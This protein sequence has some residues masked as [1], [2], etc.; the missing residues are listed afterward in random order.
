MPG[1]VRGHRPRLRRAGLLHH[2]GRHRGGPGPPARGHPHVP[3]GARPRRP[4]PHSRAARPSRHARGPRCPA[5]RGER[6][7]R[8]SP[9]A[10]PGARAGPHAALPQDAYRWRL[11]MAGIHEAEGDRE[12][13]FRLLDEAERVYFTDF[14][15]SVRPVDAV[16]ARTWARCGSVDAA[17]AWVAGTDLSL[18]DP[19]I[20]LREFEHLTLAK[21]LVA[22]HAR[23]RDGQE[24]SG[25]LVLLDRLL[26]AATEG[27]RGG[28]VIEIQVTRAL[29]LHADGGAG[30]GTHG[31]RCSPRA[32]GAGGIRP[33]LRRRGRAHGRHCWRRAAATHP[34]RT[35]LACEPHVRRRRSRSRRRHDEGRT[36]G[37]P[38]DAL[39]SRERDVLRLLDTELDGPEIARE[40]VVSLNT[41]RTHTKNLY[42]KLGV[43]SRR[44]AVVAGQ[45]ARPAL[46]PGAARSSPRHSPRVVS[47]AHHVGS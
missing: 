30:G 31:A 40:L 32:R 37:I 35:S 14:S 43:T 8:G 21:V 5:P 23:R 36:A 6:P 1:R 9:R 42:M 38:V 2:A 26:R 25:V 20:Y 45:G 19:P 18:D 47:P 11:V 13:A 15:P 33:D 17:V 3:S 39:S 27:G 34:R 28:S 10:R 46:T 4:A 24:L 22:D 29:A 12:S 7:V 44:A 16:R 41:V